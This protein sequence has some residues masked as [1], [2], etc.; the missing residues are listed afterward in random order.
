MTAAMLGVFA[1]G[2]VVGLDL[3]SLPQMMLARPLVAGAGAGLLLGDVAAGLRLGVLFELFQ[4]DILPVGATRYPEYGPA[5]VVAVAAA[6]AFAIPF[7]VGLATVVGLFTA[8]LGGLSLQV[9]RRIN[10]RAATA[11]AP[12]LDA[13]DRGALVRLHVGGLGRDLLRGAAVT[14]AGLA[15]AMLTREFVVP[16]LSHRGERLLSVAAT[17]A[18]LAA[19]AAG[20]LRIVGRGPGL[21]WLAAGLTGGILAAWLA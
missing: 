7:G 6:H 15:L 19:G 2:T 8:M 18:A 3:V 4:F 14:A 10:T 1:W 5:T 11:A 21:R 12:A 16:A 20:T 9:H 13:G 17:G